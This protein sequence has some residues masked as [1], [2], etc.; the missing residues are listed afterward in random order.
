MTEL[1]T[2][3]IP[4]ITVKD[5]NPTKVIVTDIATIRETL[6][7]E[8]VAIPE[9]QRPYKWS[10]KNVNALLDDIFHFCSNTNYRLGTI[11][12]HSD[13]KSNLKYIVDGQQRSITLSLITLAISADERLLELMKKDNFHLPVNKALENFELKHPISQENI[14]TNYREIQ[15]RII[16][17]NIDTVRFFFDRCEVVTVELEDISEAFQFFDSQ[18]ARGR[19][20]DPHDLLKAFHLREISADTPEKVVMDL[21]AKWEDMNSQSLTHLFSNYLFRIRS[22]SKGF[23]ARS[24]TKNDVGAFKGI[25]PSIKEP[26]PYA[27]IYRIAHFY[28]EGYNKEFHRNIDGNQMEFPFQLD[29]AIINGKRFFEFV[30]HYSNKIE[31]V[32]RNNNSIPNLNNESVANRILNTINTYDARNRTGDQYVRNLFDTAFVYYVDKFGYVEVERA[33]EKIF[34]WSYSLRLKRQS[35]Q[36]ASMDNYA[37]GYPFIFKSIRE[38]LQPSDFLN[39]SLSLIHESEYVESNK[40]GKL[41]NIIEKFNELKYVIK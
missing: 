37:L 15:R 10:V 13:N 14:R 33:I 32:R 4:T 40:T 11:V 7:L 26:F 21:V 28:I 12:Y 2:E 27:D 31:Q 22:W 6:A 9:Y 3:Q 23:S 38:A 25:S 34:I 1:N 18:N 20:L 29:Q 41:N 19:D 30:S 35:V 36:L 39:I 24:F 17:F 8:N 16:D 5:E